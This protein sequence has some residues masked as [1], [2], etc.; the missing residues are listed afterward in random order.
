MPFTKIKKGKG[1]GKYRSPSGRTF[2]RSQ[3]KRYYARGGTF[4]Q[5]YCDAATSLD[6]TGTEALRR[7]Y[8][9]SVE[10]RFKKVRKQLQQTIVSQD[11]LQLGTTDPSA[12]ALAASMMS[13]AVVGIAGN[14][15]DGKI[16]SFQIW[17]DQTLGRVVQENTG[18]YLD[19]MIAVAYKAG[20]V[21]GQKLTG[22]NV[23]P[24]NAMD[25]I[26]S[27]K[28]L[29]F[30][31]LQGIC[32][33]VSQRV[34]R[35]V[36]L[37]LLHN[38]TRQAL[39]SRVSKIVDVIGITRAR[40]MINQMVVQTFNQ[41]LLNQFAVA[42]VHTVGLVPETVRPSQTMPL[43]GKPSLLARYRR[44][45]PYPHRD[46][47]GPGS[48]VL[49]SLL[50]SASTIGRIQ[51][52]TA[53]LTAMGEVDIR[54]A[55]DPCPECEDLEAEGPYTINEALSLIPAHPN[56]LPGNSL[57]AS[58]GRITSATKR[59]Y[60]GDLVVI[61]TASGNTIECTPNHP[62]LTD[63]GWVAAQ[64]L[65]IGSYVIS[66]GARERCTS[67]PN[68]YH[69]PA[70]IEEIVKAFGE[71]R[72]LTL[73]P[74]TA[75]DFHGDG[76]EGD[77]AIVW[78]DRLLWGP[79]QATLRKHLDELAFQWRLMKNEL[80]ACFG[81]LNLAPQWVD[82]TSPCSIRSLLSLTRRT[83]FDIKTF[84]NL[85]N[86]IVTNTVFDTNRDLR[87]ASEILTRDGSFR[88]RIKFKGSRHFTGPV[89]NLETTK[90]YYIAGGV[91][92]HNCRCS[93]VP[94]EEE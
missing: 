24:E 30:T 8:R 91:Y 23:V 77:I 92:T 1:R 66:D 87:S 76:M 83:E 12:A 62:I 52:A 71:E 5:F 10:I 89:Y 94:T 35:E 93:F 72:S 20:L 73:C 40:S 28:Q 70:P 44:G 84:E 46:A 81:S 48:R 57:V 39:F 68:N 34:V 74:I 26:G 56:C 43:D 6:P 32:E 79:L 64:M 80:F 19:P 9:A 31:E 86:G 33:A 85:T 61:H 17:L 15:N 14:T 36:S 21:R 13:A 45:R 3:V 2:S 54:T 53:A 16:K 82:D 49:R 47:G 25:A 78:S 88:D 65:N 29:T 63:R 58:I 75:T 38:D 90:G 55:E 11:M 41:A 67:K 37:A 27:L 50:P 18:A 4:D 69:A 59:I 60:E 51:K 42:G 7:R 22:K